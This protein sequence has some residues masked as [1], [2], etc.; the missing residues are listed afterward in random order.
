MRILVTGSDG[1]IGAVLCPMLESAG[2]EVVGLDTGL[3][4]GCDFLH[5][6]DTVPT[7]WG[8][9][10]DVDAEVMSGIDAVVHLAALSN[11]PLGNVDGDLT[12]DINERASVRLAEFARDAGVRRFV[13]ASS[14]SL[15]GAGSGDLLDE[16]APFNPVTPYGESKVRAERAI[17]ELASDGFSPTYMRNA[18]AYGSSPRLRMDLLIN[19]ITARAVVEGRI[20][21]QSDGTPWR[22]FVHV[23]DIAAAVIAVLTV[24]DPGRVH[25]RAF[26]VG[27]TDENFQVRT[28]AE[29]VADAVP[30]TTISMAEDSGADRRDYRVDFA[31][32]A[33][34]LPEFQPRFTVR[35]GIE[36]LAN[37]FRK[38]NLDID[39]L[40][41]SRYI[42]LKRVAALQADGRLGEDIRWTSAVPVSP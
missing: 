3:F 11:D 18:T 32:I 35:S 24:D 36:Q 26:N 28:V 4:R 20:V 22:P 30:G 41:S 16:T 2:H 27:L 14:C 8:D 12:Y 13:F 29:M 15:Y 39:T 42:R 19:D 5:G 37:D 40:F 38:A 31:R 1:Y 23:A 25:D 9:T 21:L 6:P 17:S 34:E 33:T 10:R 7:A